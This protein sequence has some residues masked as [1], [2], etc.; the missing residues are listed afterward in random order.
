MQCEIEHDNSHKII[1]YRSIY[2]KIDNIKNKMNELKNIIDKFNNEINNIINILLK[3]KNNI[4]KYYEINNRIINNY[5]IKN[6]N[7]QRLQNIN[8]INNEIIINDLNKIIKDNNINDK[9]NNILNIFTKMNIDNKSKKNMNKE[10]NK[11]LENNN[12]EITLIYKINLNEDKIKIFG[13]DFVQK[14][15]N[16]KI[17]Y[18]NK[19]YEL[20]EY[21]DI[22][23][24]KIEI[25]LK[26]N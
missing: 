25:N 1:N 20:N 23:N 9:F 13:S 26:L 8:D 5:E 14:K 2:P 4:N 3:V 11:I 21:F 12:N 24:Y 6:R 10:D 16:C 18:E 17:K 19:E 22:K 15:N 7:Y